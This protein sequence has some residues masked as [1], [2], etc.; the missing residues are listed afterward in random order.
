[1]LQKNLLQLRTY[2][3]LF[4]SIMNALMNNRLIIRNKIKAS[5]GTENS[6]LTYEVIKLINNLNLLQNSKFSR[7]EYTA[8]L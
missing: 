5:L 7:S 3:T 4:I 1:M 8:S 2:G 6:A